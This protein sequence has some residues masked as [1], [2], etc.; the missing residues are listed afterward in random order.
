MHNRSLLVRNN[1]PFSQIKGEHIAGPSF[2]AV[3]GDVKM[4]TIDDDDDD[5]ED[6][7]MEEVS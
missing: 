7:D 5:D 2:S 1:T 4:E 6:D 3:A